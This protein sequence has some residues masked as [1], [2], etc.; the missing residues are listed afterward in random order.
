MGERDQI[1]ALKQEIKLLKNAVAD[2]KVQEVIHRAAFEVACE[3]YGLG[4]P[5]AVKKKLNV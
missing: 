5:D 4:R 2:A 3:E 1:K